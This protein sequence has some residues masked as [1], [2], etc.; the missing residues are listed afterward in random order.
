M[1]STTH[2]AEGRGGAMAGG[3]WRS[4]AAAEAE[5]AGGELRDA[6]GGRQTWGMDIATQ[7]PIEAT[8]SS[9]CRNRG[10]IC[11]SAAFAAEMVFA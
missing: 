11:A 3:E 6:E 1:Y 10:E 9:H 4:T 2:E 5:A 7:Q 8:V